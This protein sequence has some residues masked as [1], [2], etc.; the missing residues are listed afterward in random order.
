MSV[1]CSNNELLVVVF[2]FALG[3][4]VGLEKFGFSYAKF[5]L[6]EFCEQAN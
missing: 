2:V 1:Y 6:E 4:D 3:L 5:L